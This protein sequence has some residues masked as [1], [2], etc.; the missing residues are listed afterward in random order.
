MLN[1]FLK[2]ISFFIFCIVFNL[3]FAENLSNSL[4]LELGSFEKEVKSE[5]ATYK[6]YQYDFTSINKKSINKK[7]GKSSA[8]IDIN[9]NYFFILTPDGQIFFFPSENFKIKKLSIQPIQNNIQDFFNFDK[10][11]RNNEKTWFGTRDIKIIDND[12]YISFIKPISLN[13]YGISVLKS[14][15]D[16][17]KLHFSPIFN[18]DE[19]IAEKENGLL[20]DATQSGG[21]LDNFDETNFLLTIGDFGMGDLIKSK[22]PKQMIA[23]NKKSI[24]GKVLMINK[25][26]GQHKVL[27][28]GH[29]SI[30]GLFFDYEKKIILS[31]EH[32]P[33]G[34]DELNINDLKNI[35]KIKNYGWPIASDG[36]V[37]YFIYKD[38]NLNFKNHNDDNNF[39]PP[40]ISLVP[41]V[42]IS[43][44]ACDMNTKNSNHKICYVGT[45]GL[46]NY[47]SIVRIEFN[48]N[49]KNIYTAER[50]FLNDRVRDLVMIGKNI[51][52]YGET[53]STLNFLKLN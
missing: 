6:V 42:G 14:K 29:R 15:I 2:N 39:I 10:L 13:C 24:F 4:A 3:S 32:G 36:K 31:T 47:R 1:H 8:F 22:N 17:K 34:G 26:S 25:I 41:S 12:I 50:I 18:N 16:L 49:Y 11:N 28:M 44:L 52:Y 33:Q 20:F 9:N 48:D 30:N 38:S 46:N 35:P 37:Y 27:S 21:K 19:C 23:Q 51:V 40:I 5:I 45:M 43:E 53:S 7:W